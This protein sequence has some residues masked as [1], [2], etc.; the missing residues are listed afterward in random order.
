[1]I[2]RDRDLERIILDFVRE[3]KKAS[4]VE[5][6]EEVRRVYRVAGV[7]MPP[8]YAHQ[9]LF[10]LVSGRRLKQAPGKWCGE[11]SYRM[12]PRRRKRSPVK[13]GRLF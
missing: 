10:V 1:M 7:P 4:N 9:A 6:E 3:R 11:Y 2:P 13:Q 12:A 8:V 5:I